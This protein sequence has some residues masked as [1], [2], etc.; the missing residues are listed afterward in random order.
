MT[1]QLALKRRLL[2]EHRDEVLAFA[3]DIDSAPACT[4]LLR[5]LVRTRQRPR[6]SASDESHSAG[7]ER[8]DVPAGGTGVHP[9][10]RAGLGERR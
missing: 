7:A 6:R 8:S 5:M 10:A 2:V 9:C 1:R 4:E 3:P